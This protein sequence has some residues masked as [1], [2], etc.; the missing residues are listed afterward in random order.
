[1]LTASQPRIQLKITG[2]VAGTAMNRDAVRGSVQTQNGRPVRRPLQRH[3]HPDRRRLPRPIRSEKTEDPPGLNTQVQ[4]T[5]SGKAAIPL[6]QPECLNDRCHPS[7]ASLT[8]YGRK[9][10]GAVDID[11]LGR[12]ECVVLSLACFRMLQ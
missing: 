9:D 1:V 6:G 12:P 3:Q 11:D 7:S 2:Q 8:C 4:V 5:D 10:P